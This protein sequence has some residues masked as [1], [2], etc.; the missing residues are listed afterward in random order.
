MEYAL[1]R[2]QYRELQESKRVVAE[3][4]Q[5]LQYKQQLEA[6]QQWDVELSRQQ[7]IIA[8]RLPDLVDPNKGPKLKQAIKSFAINKGF[9]QQEVDSLIDARSVDVLHKAMMYENLLNTK[10][11][12]KKAKVVP[13]VTKPGTGTTREEVSSE[14]VNHLRKKAKRS[15][16]VGDA[17]KFIESLL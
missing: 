11:S 4:Q 15:G 12:K 7:G 5:D 14:K 6:Q 16:K 17:A 9:S 13:K 2:D 1:K 8:Q 3:E 10:I